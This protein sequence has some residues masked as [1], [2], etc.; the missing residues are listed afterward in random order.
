MLH[1]DYMVWRKG[2]VSSRFHELYMAIGTRPKMLISLLKEKESSL[3][4]YLAAEKAV[5][6][7]FVRMSNIRYLPTGSSII[8]FSVI[9]PPE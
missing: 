4:R 6:I 5:L 3:A 1:L 7:L 8:G 2:Q 9:T